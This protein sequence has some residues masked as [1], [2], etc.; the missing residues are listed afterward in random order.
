MVTDRTGR[1]TAVGAVSGTRGS[2]SGLATVTAGMAYSL[3]LLRRWVPAP[4]A[5]NLSCFRNIPLDK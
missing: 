3:R 5:H 2:T 4:V 1:G